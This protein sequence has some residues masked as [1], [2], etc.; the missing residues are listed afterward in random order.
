M[1]TNF[2]VLD[3]FKTLPLFNLFVI[4]LPGPTALSES[5]WSTRL[6]SGLQNRTSL[7]F[8]F[9]FVSLCFLLRFFFFLQRPRCYIS[10]VF[11]RSHLRR[12]VVHVNTRT[13]TTETTEKKTSTT[14]E[15]RGEETGPI[16]RARYIIGSDPG[17]RTG[18]RRKDS[19]ALKSPRRGARSD[20]HGYVVAR[21]VFETSDG[22]P[23]FEARGETRL[24][25]RGGGGSTRRRRFVQLITEQQQAIAPRIAR[26]LINDR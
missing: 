13:K 22:E 23:R 5:P 21:D 15:K 17:R 8:P 9:S 7:A 3:Q 18:R 2:Y 6:D 26:N 10:A 11:R 24:C 25:W 12:S 16:V 20:N 14:G 19:R 4:T 1:L